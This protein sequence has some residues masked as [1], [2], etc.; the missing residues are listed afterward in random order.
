MVILLSINNLGKDLFWQK[1][2][3]IVYVKIFNFKTCINNWTTSNEKDFKV[4]GFQKEE[5]SF[6]TNF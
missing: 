4:V 6:H 2:K 5:F 1:F 3:L